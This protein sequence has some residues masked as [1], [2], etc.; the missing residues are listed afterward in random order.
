[1]TRCTAVRAFGGIVIGV[2]VVV[3]I[4]LLILHFTDSAWLF[5]RVFFA[6]RLP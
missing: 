4:V 5:N 6:L 1:L 2:L 3:L